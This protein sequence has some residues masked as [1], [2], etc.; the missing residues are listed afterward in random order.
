V[1]IAENTLTCTVTREGLVQISFFGGLGVHRIHDPDTSP[2]N[3]VRVASLLDV[4]GCKAG[5][6]QQRA[7]AKDYLDVAAI[8]R[9]GVNLSTVL[10]AGRAVYGVQFD[11]AITL[12]A[13]TSFEEGDLKQVDPIARQEL[14]AAVFMVK[15]QQLPVLKGRPGL[16]ELEDE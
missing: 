3:G 13:L 16:Y 8:L 11:P 10:A 7:Q 4:A 2:D 9:A 15:L 6:V 14:L 1:Q 12:R 5:V